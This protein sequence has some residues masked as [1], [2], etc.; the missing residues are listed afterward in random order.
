MNDR[1]HSMVE[2]HMTSGVV[3]SSLSNT[4]VRAEIKSYE[5]QDIIISSIASS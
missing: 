5:L 1:T 4:V 3:I 2:F